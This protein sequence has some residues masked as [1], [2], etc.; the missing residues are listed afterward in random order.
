[1][2]PT[3]KAQMLIMTRVMQIKLINH[4]NKRMISMDNNRFHE[5][6]SKCHYHRVSRKQ[7]DLNSFD[8]LKNTSKQ[9]SKRNCN[10]FPIVT[11]IQVLVRLSMNI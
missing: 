7:Q 3:P 1:M 10:L 8:P 4:L 11:L 6:D 5:K 9:Y 2:V